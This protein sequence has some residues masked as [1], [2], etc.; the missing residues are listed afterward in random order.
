MDEHALYYARHLGHSMRVVAVAPGD[1][2][3]R[4]D[5]GELLCAGIMID[6]FYV[7]LRLLAEFLLGRGDP[8]DVGMPTFGVSTWSPPKDLKGR[9]GGYH[10]AA[11]KFVT[12]YSTRRVQAV[13]PTG[14]VEGFDVDPAEIDTMARDVLTG[15]DLFIARVPDGDATGTL[16]KWHDWAQE[17]IGPRD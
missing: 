4:Q 9:L 16:R 3:T 5:T 2:R 15:M 13:D 8:Q 17:R 10:E 7:N 11:S 12:H 1:L 14:P 6:A